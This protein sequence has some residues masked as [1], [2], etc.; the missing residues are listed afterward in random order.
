MLIN[1]KQI[2]SSF[3]ILTI[4]LLFNF[5]GLANTELDSLLTELRL[6]ENEVDRINILSNLG[7]YF[8]EK[9]VSKAELYYQQG[10]QISNQLLLQNN[11]F[12][13]E[14]KILKSRLL[15]GLGYVYYLTFDY[16]NAIIQL[17]KSLSIKVDV[18]GDSFE[19]KKDLLLYLG[20]CYRKLG[21]FK[22]AIDS[23]HSAFNEVNA[24]KNPEFVSKVNLALAANYKKIKFYDKAIYHYENV[25]KL[26][27]EV[28]NPVVLVYANN[29]LVEIYQENN[30]W[31]KSKRILKQSSLLS[32]ASLKRGLVKHYALYASQFNHEKQYDSARTYFE[33]GE[34]QSEKL[35]VNTGLGYIYSQYSKLEIEQGNYDVAITYASKL[36]A[37]GENSKDYLIQSEAYGLNAEIYEKTSDFSSA[38]LSVKKQKELLELS[39]VEDSKIKVLKQELVLISKQKELKDSLKYQAILQK[40]ESKLETQSLLIEEEKKIKYILLGGLVLAFLTLTI[41]VVG[42]R[43]KK[44]DNEIITAQKEESEN[45]QILLSEQNQSLQSKASLYK[46]LNV[47]SKDLSIKVVLS[48][49]LNH[50]V[51]LKFIGSYG[52]GYI[53]LK[54]EG[55]FNGVDVVSGISKNELE[56]YKNTDDRECICGEQYSGFEVEFCSNGI[57]ENHYS[58]PIVN[59]NESLGILVIFTK[60]SLGELKKNIDFFNIVS[61]LLGETVSR[62]N[63]TDKLRLAHIENTLKK[64]EIKKAHDKVNKAL[65]KQAAINDLIGAIIDNKNV[66]VQV[67]NY[68]TDIFKSTYIRRLNITLFDFEK[69]EVNFYFLRENGE[70]KLQNKPFSIHAF[71]ADTLNDLK[72]NKRVIVKSIKQK[73]IKSD[74]DLQMIKNN[75]DSFVSFPLM[76]NNKLLGSLNV[77]FEDELILADDQEEFLA[78]LTEGI[79]I[80]INQKILFNQTV[81]ASSQL[82]N[83]H[84]ELNS[85]IDYAQKI[86]EAILP[87]DEFFTDI[88]PKHFQILQQKD[89][90]G[91]DFYWVRKFKDG[92]KMVICIDCTG[93]N[94]PGAFMT[95]LARMLIR[96]A[97]TIKA[98]RNPSEILFQMDGA[99]R[100]VL[101]QDNYGGMQDGM[102]VTIC[103][104]NEKENRIQFSS[105][106]RPIIYIEKGNT[107][108][109]VVK[110]CKF[111]VGGFSEVKKE[112]KVTD[113][114]LDTVAKF[115]MVTD[116]YLDQFGGPNVKKIGKKNFIKTLNLI[117]NL[118]MSKQKEFLLN[119]LNNWKGDL[120]QIDDICVIG[121][122]LT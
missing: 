79:T 54:T 64:K 88:F 40:R 83:L 11:E 35:Q 48:E 58:I 42:L 98:L 86:Q 43:R 55:R 12:T 114:P 21:D 27:K 113:L 87:S 4:L 2:K 3:Y 107:E 99:V 105:A 97:G 92:I 121:V 73:K 20:F 19:N 110:G 117:Q 25:I 14:L 68:I 10:L 74:S 112:F 95:M 118:P 103:I 22:S 17:E 13:I 24:E 63:V 36:L 18:L 15:S 38:Y 56:V 23:F 49:V 78:M 45:H 81:F 71:S 7:D 106:H 90:V 26:S 53:Y 62:H 60:L 76:A 1:F 41:F 30:K 91:G 108:V 9:D 47:T 77:S 82:S 102:D 93:H 46:I 100:R 119:E 104:I 85:S 101:K 67:F 34:K 44:K 16:K 51:G 6:N 96:E 37:L 66:G 65:N 39:A 72:A 122:D 75:I 33:L 116:G 32:K 109:T 28:G 8:V 69:E 59:N 57:V 31:A 89:R 111:S 80:A 120:D 29:G 94:V 50:L 115:Y 84:N 52:K 61:K 5:K 70:D